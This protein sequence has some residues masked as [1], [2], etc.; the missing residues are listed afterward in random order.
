MRIAAVA[1]S[2]A[3]AACAS[4]GAVFPEARP[5][6]AGGEVLLRLRRGG[7]LGSCPSY[8]VTVYRDG[9]V[10]YEGQGI[11]C[12]PGPISARLSV[13]QMAELRAAIVRS[14]ISTVP[15]HC[16]DRPCSDTPTIV[17]TVAEPLPERT[18]IDSVCLSEVTPVQSLASD[19]DR[20][21]RIE[22]WIGTKEQREN[23]VW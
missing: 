2:F 21:L 11:V 19:V 9:A 18:L 14:H 15:L 1:V 4:S 23:Y 17:L 3:F 5:G 20:V 12:D 22:R 10:R 8:V 13:E 7:C 16:C 6:P